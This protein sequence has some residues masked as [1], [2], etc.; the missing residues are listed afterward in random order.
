MVYTDE[1]LRDLD[2][3]LGFIAEHYPMLVIP[4]ENRLGA[5]MRRIGAW[6]QSAAEVEERPGVR[7]LPLI[8]YPYKLFYRVTVDRVEILHLYHA[9]RREPWRGER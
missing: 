4:F 9:S 7:M 5:A 6:P 1:A 8:P 3:I 2:D